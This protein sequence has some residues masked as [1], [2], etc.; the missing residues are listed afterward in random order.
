[1]IFDGHA[2]TFPP[3]KGSGGF[4]DPGDLRRHL[5]QA[6][7]VHHQPEW[8]VS[9]RTRAHNKDLI[10]MSEWQYLSALK[11]S[12]FTIADNGRFEWTSEGELFAKQYFPPSIID[13]SYPPDR[14]ISEMDYAGVDKALLHR[15]PY[16]GI[17]NDFIA[18]CVAKYPDRLHGLAHVREWKTRTDPE[19]SIAN[20]ERAIEIQG[21]SG[22]HFLPPQLD[23]YGYTGPWDTSEFHTFWD[24]VAKMNIPVFFSLKERSSPEQESYIQD[25]RTLIRWMERYPDVQV[26]MTHGMGWRLFI[27]GDG[28]NISE[29][30][31][32]AFDNANLYLQWLFPIALGN[33]WDYPMP[34]VRPTMEECV[35]RIGANRIMWG[36]DMP[37]VMRS[38]TYQQNLDFIRNYTGFLSEESTNAILGGTVSRLLGLQELA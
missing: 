5:Q 32:R 18:E 8:R 31:W 10:N 1:M 36:T 7:A 30:V 6:I 33:V 22:L 26:I 34:Q 38:W 35:S 17:G 20:L 3:L 19:G 37:I 2:Y 28:L 23:L 9:D 4:S 13:M 14:L 15:T 25:V 12:D 11:T 21:L 27:D 24:A 29:E 16:L